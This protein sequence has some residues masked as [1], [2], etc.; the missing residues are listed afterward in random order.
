MYQKPVEYYPNT[1]RGNKAGEFSSWLDICREFNS[2]A[3][4][5]ADGSLETFTSVATWQ[6]LGG[7]KAM[8]RDLASNWELGDVPLSE[9]L[10]QVEVL[11][12]F[13]N[14]YCSFTCRCVDKNT[15]ILEARC[16]ANGEVWR[17]ARQRDTPKIVFTKYVCL[18]MC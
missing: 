2:H 9:S 1:A 5:T 4:L 7:Q 10:A 15:P 17:L 12:Y 8:L 16:T 3:R 11:L 14:K 18:H 6:R 13:R